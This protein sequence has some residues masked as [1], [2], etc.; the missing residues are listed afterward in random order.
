MNRVYLTSTADVLMS[1]YNMTSQGY[2]Q[3]RKQLL[4]LLL[5]V[6]PLL[7]FVIHFIRTSIVRVKYEGLA[8]GH[9]RRLEARIIFYFGSGQKKVHLVRLGPKTGTY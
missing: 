6:M 9:G 5:A 1:W 2:V 4:L 8:L 3:L 7:F